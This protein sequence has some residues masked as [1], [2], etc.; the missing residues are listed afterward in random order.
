MGKEWLESI[1]K[2]IKFLFDI[3]INDRVKASILEAVP[4]WIAAL[5]TGFVAVGY[6]MFF[7]WSEGLLHAAISWNR[8]IIFIL[9]PLNFL[10]AWYV[11]RMFAPAAGGSGIPQVMA[12]IDL[13]SRKHERSISQLISFRTLVTKIVSTGFMV[14]GGGAI[15]REGPTIQIAGSIFR[16]VNNVIPSSWPKLSQRNYILTGA[17][18][19]LAAAFNT[20]LGGIVFAIEE[21]AKIHISLFRTAL[22][23]SVIIAGLAAQALLGSYLYL[24]FPDVKGLSLLIFLG[25]AFCAVVAGITGALMCKGILG[26]IRWKRSFN[27]IKS[28][29]FVIAAGLS[30]AAIAYF[31][32]DNI[33]GSGKNIMNDI[34]FSKDKYVSWQTMLVRIVGPIISFSTGG[35]GG[36][37][38]PSL[39]AGAS[40]GSV[41]SDLFGISGANANI[42]ILS[43][44]VG[45]LTGVTRTP[46]TSAILVLEMTDRHSVIFHLML[47]ALI[48]NMVALIVDRRSFYGQL[49]D[50]FITEARTAKSRSAQPNPANPAK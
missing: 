41:L 16:L 17:A 23:A 14:L 12:A 50:V 13:S 8:E 1:R 37:F 18:A 48:S 30:M 15:G 42:L 44:M 31:I 46:F 21:L 32:D 3:V 49:R 24:G 33:L 20:P 39:A 11:I 34:L 36:I 35:A 43:G 45:F 19:G 29:V 38:A 26:V 22:F 28:I 27:T 47:A 5:I 40:V 7:D 4:F 9:A 25:V 2:N 10:L 6:T